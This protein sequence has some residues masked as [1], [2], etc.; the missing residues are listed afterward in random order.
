MLYAPVRVIQSPKAATNWS[1][2]EVGNSLRKLD[3]LCITQ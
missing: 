3:T 2:P 1:V